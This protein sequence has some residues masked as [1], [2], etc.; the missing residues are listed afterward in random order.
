MPYKDK[1]K[2]RAYQAAYR[3]ANQEKVRA[4]K[5]K[6]RT[7]NQERLRA[8]DKEYYAANLEK[9]REYC[10]DYRVLN[11][12]K[13]REY[14]AA[15]YGANL[16]LQMWRK[17]KNRAKAKNIPF[18]LTPNDINIPSTCPVLGTKLERGRGKPG[19]NSPSLDRIVPARGYVPENVIVVSHRA[20]VIKNDATPEELALVTAF[21]QQIWNKSMEPRP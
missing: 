17:A 16:E 18:T 8:Y 11:R 10:K 13:A 9:K 14:R 6:Y 7:A 3:T 1:E 15:Y 12:E 20:N 5:K 19:P 21:Y 2:E 4:A